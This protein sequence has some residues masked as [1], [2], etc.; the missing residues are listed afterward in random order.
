MSA[1]LLTILA[2]ISEVYANV[3]YQCSVECQGITKYQSACASHALHFFAKL[4]QVVRYLS[5]NSDP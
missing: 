5:L 1:L 2:L 3:I 4:R